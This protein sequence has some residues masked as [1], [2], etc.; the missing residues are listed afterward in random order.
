MKIEFDLDEGEIKEM[1]TNAVKSEVHKQVSKVTANYF[2]C[3]DAR[4]ELS[5]HIKKWMDIKAPV[6]IDEIFNDFPAMKEKAQ[7][8]ITNSLSQRV[9]RTM[10]RMEES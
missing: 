3:W 5:D 6:L 4:D 10:K 1:V 2:S 7:Q 9:A 8:T